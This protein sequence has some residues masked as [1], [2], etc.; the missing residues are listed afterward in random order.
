MNRAVP[1]A[2]LKRSLNLWVPSAVPS[3]T[4]APESSSRP[5][6]GNAGLLSSIPT[7][8]NHNNRAAYSA[9]NLEDGLLNKVSPGL[10]IVLGKSG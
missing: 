2:R 7:G 10:R 8:C 5:G 9:E 6:V 4:E 1:E 3:G